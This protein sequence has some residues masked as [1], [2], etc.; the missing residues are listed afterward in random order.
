[1]SRN[2][3]LGLVG[4]AVLALFGLWRVS[5]GRAGRER[6]TESTVLLE[7]PESREL[8][9]MEPP[10]SGEPPEAVQADESEPFAE[11]ASPSRQSTVPAS[12]AIT[13]RVVLPEGFVPSEDVWIMIQRGSEW[14]SSGAVMEADG[15]FGL[16]VPAGR[17]RVALSI[18]SRFLWLPK[19]V[20]AM[21]GEQEVEL[22]PL[23][24]GVIEGVVVPPTSFATIGASWT[25]VKLE[26]DLE[27]SASLSVAA[28]RH[29]RPRDVH[30]GDDGA[31][32]LAWVAPGAGILLHA[33]NPFGPD[34]L[35]GLEP[36]A[37]GEVR[38]V[39]IALEPGITVSGRVIDEHGQPAA[40]VYLELGARGEQPV[41][42]SRSRW[43]KPRPMADSEGRFVIARVARDVTLVRTEEWDLLEQGEAEFDGRD[44][45]VR[46]L[47]L[48]VVRGSSIE[49]TVQWPDGA[50][51][52]AFEVEVTGN[53]RK[54]EEGSGG[55]FRVPGLSGGSYRV[56]VRAARG[57]RTGRAEAPAVVSDGPPLSLILEEAPGC[58]V[59]ASVV[60]GSDAPLER[61]WVS[62]YHAPPDTQDASSQGLAGRFTLSGLAPGS[63]LVTVHA[64]GHLKAE[65]NVEL[66][67]GATEL[68]FVLP[69]AGRVRGR[70][71]DARS[72]PV[73]GA[74]V[75]EANSA[76]SVRYF[77]PHV[78]GTDADGRF[79][80]EVD[81]TH[82]RLVAI[83]N[84][85]GPSE[86]QTVEVEPGQ[87]LEH[88][89]FRLSEG[90]RVAGSVFDERGAPLSGA[91][92]SPLES[93]LTLAV[94][95][96]QGGF[97]LEG[98]PPGPLRLI[99]WHAERPDAFATISLTL[100]PDQSEPVELRFRDR[101]PVRV[102]GRITRG[103]VPFAGALVLRT[104]GFVMQCV[105]DDGGAFEIDLQRPGAWTGI[106]SP[107]NQESSVDASEDRRLF[108]I[109]GPDAEQYELVLDYDALRPVM[110]PE[111]FWR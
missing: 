13:G 54:T 109:T 53:D 20:H 73:A 55:R 108:T 102:A 63:W 66:A 97:V 104:D 69:S 83:A 30:P 48:R 11:R 62:A 9:G 1:M 71:L 74:W 65:Q 15:F 49:G 61:F 89:E 52:E 100:A 107:G 98:L 14:V 67:P 34:W 64:S 29:P 90:C 5:G 44:G 8:V 59:R 111:E 33:E 50:P 105:T 70:V 3:V 110:S 101:D 18:A 37:P 38:R 86:I 40:F 58:E 92:V 56:E 76:F 72:A 43:S 88:L 68:R 85:H 103:G 36:L 23:V 17:D 96:A 46:D 12:S 10:S 25:D 39:E 32:E 80:F 81:A 16:N 75:G 31:F 41:G 24:F 6:A 106:I 95:D 35:Q 7:S 93:E 78:Q 99:A 91:N 57:G 42:S 28:N 77:G 47:V 51:A 94:T 60:D 4:V 22:R 26:W 45:D 87:T 79:D 84:G 19:A 2:L 27:R 82:L 21:P